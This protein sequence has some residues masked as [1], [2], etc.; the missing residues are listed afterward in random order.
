MDREQRTDD[1]QLG[2]ESR[3]VPPHVGPILQPQDRRS[4][5]RALGRSLMTVAVLVVVYYALPLKRSFG[6]G[7]V[8]VLVT[9]LICLTI[10]VALQVRSI[11]RSP[12]P[13]MRA[14]E[15]LALTVP[16]FL[17]IFAMV[18]VVLSTSDPQAFSQPLTRT[19]SL[20]F[21][22]TVFA[23]VGFG[24][25]TAVSETARVL[26]TIQMVSDLL[27]LGLVVRAVIS[28]VQRSSR[29]RSGDRAK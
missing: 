1:G 14:V 19:D 28:A 17:L 21:V 25:I 5:A 2:N 26:V 9:A 3:P 4:L 18:Y 23:T 6:A 20:Y 27:V 15:S 22:I 13:A 16:L 12:N 11:I 7:T 8:V 24:D 10:L 29:T